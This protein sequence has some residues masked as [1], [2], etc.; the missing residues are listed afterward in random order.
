MLDQWLQICDEK[1]YIRPS[2]Y[3]GQYS[4]FC[5]RPE[6]RLLPWLRRQGIAFVGFSPLAGGFLTGKLTS[7]GGDDK[8]LSGTRFAPGNAMGK[9]FRNWYDKPTI[10]AAMAKFQV[11]VDQH[12][13]S[14]TETA[15]RWVFYHSSLSEAD[16]VLLGSSRPHQ[17]EDATR[18]IA[19]GPLSPGLA[20]QLD[21]LWDMIRDEAP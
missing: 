11:M 18:D 13:L 12:G 2:V 20:V 8:D 1:G 17:V 14:M 4:L 15:L 3:Q 9:A 7:S 6:E 19:K 16:A 10:H 5:R 21:D